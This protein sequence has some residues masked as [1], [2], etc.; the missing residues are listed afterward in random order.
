TAAL[1]GQFG[2]PGN[3]AAHGRRPP[4]DGYCCRTH[5]QAERTAN[6]V[7]V[8]QR[9]KEGSTRSCS[10]HHWSCLFFS[11]RRVPTPRTDVVW[12]S[13]SQVPQMVTVATSPCTGKRKIGSRVSKS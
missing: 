11:S 3:R 10:R 9:R 4:P 8:P 2:V 6:N 13:T 1:H 5:E 7:V 12:P